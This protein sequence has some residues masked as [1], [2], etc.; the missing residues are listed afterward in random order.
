M[1]RY[2]LAMIGRIEDLV[3]G[4]IEGASS[5]EQ[6]VEYG[7]QREEICPVIDS[8]GVPELLGCH[9]SGS[10]EAAARDRRRGAVLADSLGQPEVCDTRHQGSPG[11]LTR[12]GAAQKDISRLE[13]PVHQAR[14]V[15]GHQS[16][17]YRAGE[18]VYLLQLEWNGLY[19]E[20]QVRAL[21]ELQHEYRLLVEPDQV[22]DAYDIWVLQGPLGTALPYQALPE[23]RRRI[24]NDLERMQ[25]AKVTVMSQVDRRVAPFPHELLDLVATDDG[26]RPDLQEALQAEGT[27]TLYPWRTLEDDV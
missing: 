12:T 6:L 9:V 24:L 2:E 11:S 23:L 7:S 17:H 19:E 4:S 14:P 10:P 1:Q 25:G 8:T 3:Y 20:T 26:S 27:R 16:V 22:R 5:G 13:I 21:H 18:V 15:G